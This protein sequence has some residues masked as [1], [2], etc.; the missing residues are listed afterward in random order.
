MHDRN[1]AIGEAVSPILQMA[2]EKSDYVVFWE[3]RCGG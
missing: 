2:E 3:E 1:L